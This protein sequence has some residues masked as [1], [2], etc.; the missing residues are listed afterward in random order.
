MNK[1]IETIAKISFESW[2]G[3]W[4]TAPEFRRAQARKDALTILD[5][6]C[7]SEEAKRDLMLFLTSTDM[8]DLSAEIT[9]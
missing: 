2:G 4:A 8:G 7:K 1:A 6:I 9:Q 3:P 5:G